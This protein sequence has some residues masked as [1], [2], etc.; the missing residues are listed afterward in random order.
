MSV[1]HMISLKSITTNYL[2]KTY[3]GLRSYEKPTGFKCCC[4][5]IFGGNFSCLNRVGLSPLKVKPLM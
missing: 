1:T 5:I 2:D 3:I 4:Q